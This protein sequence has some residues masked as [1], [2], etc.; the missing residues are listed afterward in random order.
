MAI[1]AAIRLSTVMCPLVFQNLCCCCCLRELCVSLIYNLVAVVYR[2]VHNAAEAR[3]QLLLQ[4]CSL[5]LFEK[6][7]VNLQDCGV[8][9]PGA[10]ASHLLQVDARV[11]NALCKLRASYTVQVA[12]CIATCNNCTVGLTL[13]V[14][15]TRTTAATRAST[16]AHQRNFAAPRQRFAS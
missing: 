7:R 13:C 1:L 3:R 4:S 8:G 6:L 10:A 12:T 5:F 2:S 16:R 11:E 14:C 9:S 15:E